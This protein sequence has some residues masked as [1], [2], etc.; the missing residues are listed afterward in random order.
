MTTDPTT[1]SKASVLTEAA[2]GAWRTKATSVYH[3]HKH[4]QCYVVSLDDVNE[5]VAMLREALARVDA[6]QASRETVL[7]ERDSFIS[8]LSNCEHELKGAR[9]ALAAMTADRDELQRKCAEYDGELQHAGKASR[10]MARQLK[11]ARTALA[12][13]TEAGVRVREIPDVVTKKCEEWLRSPAASPHTQEVARFVLA[14]R[15]ALAADA[16]SEP[17]APDADDH[18]CYRC[19]GSAP[20]LRMILCPTCGNKRCPKAS[21]HDLAC[22]GSN[23]AGQPGSVY[24]RDPDGEKEAS[25]HRDERSQLERLRAW[26]VA[27]SKG[28]ELSARVALEAVM[29]EID[30]MRGEGAAEPEPPLS[31]SVRRI[32][33][34]V[35]EDNDEGGQIVAGNVNGDLRRLC[36]AVHLVARAVESRI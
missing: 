11:D 3:A 25:P 34:H 36:N 22:T 23:E 9:T 29:D 31:D 15:E 32:L 1:P 2:I 7:S 30:R 18:C 19:L 28:Q 5:V 21:D 35:G 16:A 20:R 6:L 26:V 14:L 33:M 24:A 4:S 10:E 8:K 13:A 27:R 17:A 12:A